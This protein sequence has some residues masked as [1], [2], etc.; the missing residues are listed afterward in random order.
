MSVPIDIDAVTAALAANRS[1]ESDGGSMLSPQ[2][3]DKHVQ[4]LKALRK[5]LQALKQLR[6]GPRLAADAGEADGKS[7]GGDSV[8]SAEELGATKGHV[9]SRSDEQVE[10]PPSPRVNGGRSTNSSGDGFAGNEGRPRI[11]AAGLSS[12]DSVDD[13]DG[14]VRDSGVGSGGERYVAGSSEDVDGALTTHTAAS[15]VTILH[16]NQELGRSKG[17]QIGDVQSFAEEA[18]RIGDGG[19]TRQN[20]QRAAIDDAGSTPGGEDEV[21]SRVRSVDSSGLGKN[22][23]LAAPPPAGN[24]EAKYGKFESLDEQWLENS[25]GSLKPAIPDVGGGATACEV[26]SWGSREKIDAFTAS[27]HGEGLGDNTLSPPGTPLSRQNRDAPKQASSDSNADDIRSLE[28]VGRGVALV[29]LGDG[30]GTTTC[31][32]TQRVLLSADDKNAI[33]SETPR[34]PIS[35]SHESRVPVIP[36]ELADVDVLTVGTTGIGF[37]SYRANKGDDSGDR[38]GRGGGGDY[39]DRGHKD[40]PGAGT[41]VASSNAVPRKSR[42]VPRHADGTAGSRDGA[43]RAE[44]AKDSDE[45]RVSNTGNY[46]ERESSGVGDCSSNDGIDH[47]GGWAEKQEKNRERKAAFDATHPCGVLAVG[48]GNLDDDAF[49]SVESSVSGDWIAESTEDEEDNGEAGRGRGKKGHPTESLRRVERGRKR[50]ETKAAANGDG[51]DAA[52]G[53]PAHRQVLKGGT[54]CMYAGESL[55]LRLSTRGKIAQCQGLLRT[56]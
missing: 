47:E 8:A 50:V 28:N 12:R 35:T 40:K 27:E 16:R 31:R 34:L 48:S 49:G 30:N 10:A 38:D 21:T 25:N 26:S 36:V 42:V 20:N 32:V 4:R 22:H 55:G 37:E 54:G 9:H 2:L 51:S 6:I 23:R 53:A 45:S 29:R 17:R 43:E 3:K 5:R 52:N 14:T 15:D 18:F 11:E 1:G 33:T 24:T 39:S 19:N 56:Q 41:R 44:G 7:V 13:G 46:R